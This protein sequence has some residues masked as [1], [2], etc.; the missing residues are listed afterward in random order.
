MAKSDRQRR[1]LRSE[2]FFFDSEASLLDQQD[3]EMSSCAFNDVFD[4]RDSDMEQI[5]T[6]LTNVQVL[7]EAARFLEGT[8]RKD[9]S[10]FNR[11]SFHHF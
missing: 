8:D 3:L 2:E 5:N 7:L 6:F 9:G 10:E 1:S 4:S 11:A